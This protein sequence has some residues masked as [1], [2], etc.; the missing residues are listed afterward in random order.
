METKAQKIDKLGN[1]KILPLIFKY[2]WPAVVSMLLNQLYNIVDRIYIGHGCGKDAIAG[3][4][5]TTPIMI[6]LGAI[7]VLIGMGCAA[8]ESIYL[9][10]GDKDNA[11]KAL[12]QCVA[13]KLIFGLVVPP[14]MYFFGFGPILGLLSDGATEATIAIAHR[15]LSIIIFFNLFAHLGFG[16]SAMMRAEGSP[17]Q[18]M[19][20]MLAGCLTN[21]IC[22]P[23][24]IFEAIK[25][26]YTS[27]VIPGLG[28][29][30]V[31][32]AWATN[33]AMIATCMTALFFYLSKR[34]IVTLRLS[35]IRIY[36][37]LARRSL[38]IGLSPCLMQVM[39]SLISF[40]INFAF[41]KWSA[42]KEIGTIQMSAYGIYIA[43]TMLFF[44][45]IMGIQQG[46]SPIIGYNWGAESYA[47][48]RRALVLGLKLSAVTSIIAC[49]GM[50]AFSRFLSGWFADDKDVIDASSF[51]LRVGTCMT[52]SIFINVAATTYFQ[53]VGRP[54]TAIVLSLFRQCIF[55]L[56][57]IWLLPYCIENHILGIWLALPISDFVT[58]VASIPPLIKEYRSLG[59]RLLAKRDARL[60][61]R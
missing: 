32:A 42:S 50:V 12:G 40:S 60:A 2:A 7:G 10:A 16:L 57:G 30:V 44:I 11:E 23:F 8:I 37:E 35:R 45:P 18:S 47:R 1:G 38:A 31:G 27:I 15:Y 36:P 24:F 43:V 17:K 9:G 39:G 6:F 13:M 58:G 61:A 4:A 54:T 46:I 49:V 21:I 56:P 5:L 29:G 41:A 52:W 3:L 51:A 33:L 34:S 25:I 22:D 20:C 55:L 59:T 28:K 19:Y 26:P 53:A 48:V 14:L